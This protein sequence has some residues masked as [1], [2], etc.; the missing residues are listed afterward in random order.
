MSEVSNI[1]NLFKIGL[2]REEFISEYKKLS[3]N[4]SNS[5]SIFSNE[6][7]DS[8]LNTMFNTLHIDKSTKKTDKLSQNDITHLANTDGDSSSISDDDI[9]ALYESTLKSAKVETGSIDSDSNAIPPSE[10]LDLLNSLRTMKINSAE[11][12][13]EKL[14]A[15]IN[16]LI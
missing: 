14:Q 10:A 7:D 11:A 15:E 3:E 6:L 1:N 5:G 13:K 9:M 8:V 12:K 2:S 16:E 4:K